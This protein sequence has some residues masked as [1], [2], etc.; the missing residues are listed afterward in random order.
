MTVGDQIQLADVGPAA[1]TVTS[2]DPSDKERDLDDIGSSPRANGVA[3]TRQIWVDAPRTDLI[4][5]SE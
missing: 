1:S 2:M 3:Q 4:V 5:L